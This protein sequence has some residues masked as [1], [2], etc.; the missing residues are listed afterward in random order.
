MSKFFD[1]WTWFTVIW[2]ARLL[3][4]SM[5]AKVTKII[6]L[7]WESRFSLWTVSVKALEYWSWGGHFMTRTLVAVEILLQGETLLICRTLHN[8][9]PIGSNVSFH[10]FIKEFH[11]HKFEIKWWLK[12]VLLELGLVDESISTNAASLRAC[13]CWGIGSRVDCT[14]LCLLNSLSG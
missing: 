1:Y 8:I 7:S 9:T 3:K 2:R 14:W 13:W 4:L 6:V 11:L 10:M 5:L 12:D